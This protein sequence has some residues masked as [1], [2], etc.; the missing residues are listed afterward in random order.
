M[1]DDQYDDDLDTDDD[2][3]EERQPNPVRKQ[4]RKL[5]RELRD[6]RK[7]A[8]EG[9]AARRELAF[10]RAGVDP[11]DPK[12]R[13]FVK[14]YD[15]ALD[16]TAIRSEAEAAGIIAP[17]PPP[18]EVAAH[19]AANGVGAQGLGGDP[20]DR[21]AD[22]RAALGQTKSQAEVLA[23]MTQYGSEIDNIV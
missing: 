9:E 7:Q 8:E 21:T 22:Y 18:P 6:V 4:M 17:P 20:G 13:Y 3:L 2:D 10:I 19:N 1:P 5:E 14:G 23:T 15:G 11:E 12:A 16:P